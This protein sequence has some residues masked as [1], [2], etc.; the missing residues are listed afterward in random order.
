MHSVFE[1]TP[2]A[3]AVPITFVTRSTWDAI[4]ADLPAHAKQFATA[5]GFTA[6]PGA[7]LT[8]PDAEG[9]IAQVLFG[10]EDAS[11][12]F[13]DLFRP[14]ALPGLLPAGVYRLAHAPHDTRLATPA[15]GRL[16]SA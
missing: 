9:R 1:T 10:L 14:G 11:S 8:L 4:R 2:A 12:K 15:V 5:N 7:W 6:K 3:T 13:R 16:A